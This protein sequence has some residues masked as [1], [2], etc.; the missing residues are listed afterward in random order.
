[1]FQTVMAII[2]R[3]RATAVEDTVGVVA[4]FV[5]LFAVLSM[6]GLA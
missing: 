1:M 2:N 3:D 4:L 6:P 5:L